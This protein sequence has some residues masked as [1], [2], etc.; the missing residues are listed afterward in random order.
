MRVR[1][2]PAVRAAVLTAAAVALLPAIIE[3]VYV[4][5]AAV[6]MDERTGAA[7]VTIGNSGDSPEEATV[8]LR[9]GFPD[10]DSAGTPFIRFVDDPGTAFPSAADWS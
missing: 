1:L 7:Q 10:A 2:K 8:E 5:P 4:S 9:F 3:A 6:F